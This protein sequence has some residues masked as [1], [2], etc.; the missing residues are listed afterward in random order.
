VLFNREFTQSV[1]ISPVPRKMSVSI[2]QPTHQRPAS[3]LKHSNLWVFLQFIGIWNEANLGNP[4]PFDENI[5]SVQILSRG[6]K[7]IDIGEQDL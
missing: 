5:P 3:A 1:Q 4:L 2:A 6:V 7:N